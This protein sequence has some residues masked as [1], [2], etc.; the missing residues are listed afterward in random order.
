VNPSAFYDLRELCEI[1][2]KHR[3][4]RALLQ[5]WKQKSTD[6]IFLPLHG[7]DSRGAIRGKQS[8]GTDRG[9]LTTKLLRRGD[10]QQEFA[11]NSLAIARNRS[12]D[13]CRRPRIGANISRVT[14]SNYKSTSIFECAGKLQD[15]RFAK[16][17]TQDLQAHWKSCFCPS[18]GN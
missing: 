16:V 3:E 18:T 9:Y 10:W 15:A 17:R 14:R 7:F 5:K 12:S 13:I 1:Q 8:S 2:V 6:E 11:E 4:G